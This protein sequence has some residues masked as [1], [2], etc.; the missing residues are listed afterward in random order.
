MFKNKK[1]HF[2]FI[3]MICTT[4]VYIMSCYNV[5]L[6]EGFSANIFL[7]AILGFPA[8]FVFALIGD[9]FVVGKIVGRIAPKFIKEGDSM[10][11]VGI[12]M[13]FFTCCGMVLWMSFFGAV[14]NV[15]FGP[16]LLPAYGM[17]IIKNFIFAIPLN[18]LIVSPLMR[19]IFFKMF[20]PVATKDLKEKTA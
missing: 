10:A 11:K 16:N 18:L 1:E 19:T 2:I 7:H 6:I 9:I 15:G 17:G 8:A 20:P 5:A 3:L 13:S 4:M 14:T 12:V